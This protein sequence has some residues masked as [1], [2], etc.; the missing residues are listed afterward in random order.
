[1]RKI[2][3]LLFFIINY[4]LFAQDADSVIIVKDQTKMLNIGKQVYILEDKGGKLMIGD[5]QKPEYQAKFQKSTQETPNFNVTR[6]TIWVKLTVANQTDEKIYLEVG[7]AMAWYIDFYKPNAD[8]K[9]DLTTQTGM[10][11]PIDNREVDNNFFLFEL[12]NNP[13]HQTYYFAIRSDGPLNLPLIIATKRGL[14]E[15]RTIYIWFLGGFTGLLLIMFFYNLFIYFSVKDSIYLYYCAYIIP[16]LVNVNYISGNYA[17]KLNIISYFSNYF[18]AINFTSTLATVAFIIKLLQLQKKHLAYKILLS[19]LLL[20]FFCALFNLITGHFEPVINILQASFLLAFIYILFYG[21]YQH[22]KGNQNAK[23]LVFGFSF[24]MMGTIIYICQNFGLITTNF[25]TYNSIVL[26]T[27]I[28]IALFSLALAERINRMRMEKEE[29]QFALL[30]QTLENDRLVKEQNQFLEQRIIER[31]LELDQAHTKILVLEKETTEKQL[32]GGFAHEMRNALV[33]PKLVIQHILGQDGSKPYESISLKNSR[34]LKEIYLLVKDSIPAE[35]LQ[36]TLKAM[37]EI[38]QNEE[39]ID[40]SLNMIYEAVSK[41]L[42]ITQLIMNYSKVGNEQSGKIQIDLNYLLQN[43][44]EQYKK[45][46][47]E[48]RIIFRLDL[49]KE[50]SQILGLETHIESVYKNLLLNAKDALLDKTL[51]NGKEKAIEIKTQTL[52]NRFLIEITDNGIGISDEHIGKIYDAFFSTKPDTGTGLGLGVVKKIIALYD[53][54]IEVKSE[55]GKGTMFTV[56][57]PLGKE[58]EINND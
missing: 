36:T 41:G 25:W 13:S 43:I 37:Q 49:T 34:R 40:D 31:T 55:L 39:Q 16:T 45:D 15:H 3:P 22:K 32:A 17:Y 30:T 58:K 53:G 11:R 26:G 21:A 6:S 57:L 56:T 14:L 23:F 9:P 4:S 48:Q 18:T 19:W 29:S 47:S 51:T 12:A 50:K 54:K 7:Q 38:F 42:N 8:G 5:I 1:M 44:V 28:E 20:H 35:T 46:W 10:M 27:S 33:G 2:L 24:Y 52:N